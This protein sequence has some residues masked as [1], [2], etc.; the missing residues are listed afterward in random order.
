LRNFEAAHH[1]EQ[2]NGDQPWFLRQ[3]ASSNRFLA[4]LLSNFK[5]HLLHSHDQEHDRQKTLLFYRRVSFSLVFGFSHF[6][7]KQETNRSLRPLF[8]NMNMTRIVRNGFLLDSCVADILNLVSPN[9][10]KGCITT[11]LLY[12]NKLNFG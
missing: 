2:P 9:K 5:N 4:T 7:S 12:K 8:S 10:T 3:H 6:Y 11:L 1:T